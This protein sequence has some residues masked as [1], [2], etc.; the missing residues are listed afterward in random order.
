MNPHTLRFLRRE[1][2]FFF[3][4]I[5]SVATM[6]DIVEGTPKRIGAENAPDNAPADSGNT[7]GSEQ[8]PAPTAPRTIPKVSS[9]AEN[10]KLINARTQL[11]SNMSQR[12][13][14][15]DYGGDATGARFAGKAMTLHLFLRGIEVTM[16]R[17]PKLMDTRYYKVNGEEKGLLKPHHA[18]DKSVAAIAAFA[19][20]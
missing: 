11:T 19:G 7:S 8:E 16:K 4:N 1:L 6:S 2:L 5:P 9:M 13:A 12:I 3:I 18:T 10:I 15:T 17:D 14:N 20:G